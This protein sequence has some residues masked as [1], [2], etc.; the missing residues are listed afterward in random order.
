MSPQ[1]SLEVPMVC[2]AAVPTAAA[3][4]PAGAV[5]VTPVANQHA[6]VTRGKHSFRQS[7]LFEATPLSPVPRTYRAALAY[8]NWW[9][10]M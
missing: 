8:P 1:A 9:T 3:P 6:M 5:P 10:A 7:A 2:T 4:I